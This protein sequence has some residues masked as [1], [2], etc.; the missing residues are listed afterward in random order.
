[1][2]PRMRARL[3]RRR[4]WSILACAVVLLG[5]TV[6]MAH[7]TPADDHMGEAAAVCLAVLA[8]GA[9]LAALP[10]LSGPVPR[11]RAQLQLPGPNTSP[12]VVCAV[13][14]R[15]RGDPSLLQVFRR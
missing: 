9:A 3:R 10:A 4:G 6:A 2:L 12:A 5:A 13:P 8:G 7:A 15:P 14:H 11:Q 1:M